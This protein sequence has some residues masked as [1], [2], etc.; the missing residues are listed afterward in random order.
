MKFSYK[1]E[2]VI[3]VS[4][5][6]LP[7]SA[8]ILLNYHTHEH[9]SIHFQNNFTLNYSTLWTHSHISFCMSHEVTI[10]KVFAE[11]KF[12]LVMFETLKRKVKIILPAWLELISAL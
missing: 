8:K 6:C 5:V 3:Y 2:E 7:P 9:I 10:A 4:V 12:S 1:N 11:N